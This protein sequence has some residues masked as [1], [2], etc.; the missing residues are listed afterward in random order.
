MLS[1]T[2]E[3]TMQ[4][5]PGDR[6]RVIG[7]ADKAHY[8]ND[9]STA[10]VVDVKS[11]VSGWLYAIGRSDANAHVPFMTQLLASEDYEVLAC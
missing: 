8:L 6:V 5:K 7:A 1:T 2:K 9:G 10:I 11:P 4:V 3:L